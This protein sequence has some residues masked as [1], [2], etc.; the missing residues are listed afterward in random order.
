MQSEA[1]HA[2][3]G[4]ATYSLISTAWPSGTTSISTTWTKVTL[5]STKDSGL[6]VAADEFNEGY[7]WVSST[8]T[9][10][11]QLIKIKTQPVASSGT[12]TPW[13][14]TFEDGHGFSEIVD[15]GSFVSMLKNEYDDLIAKPTAAQTALMVGVTPCDVPATYYFWLQTWGPCPI[16]ADSVLGIG[17][18]VCSGTQ[19]AGAV[20]SATGSTALVTANIPVG[21]DMAVNVANEAAMVHLTLAP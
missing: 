3:Y 20:D 6:T 8:S 17:E 9:E 13:D 19:L 21:V 15:S 12:T 1:P 18:V 2:A 16:K 14:I 11:G 5:S 4:N 10:Q 7:L